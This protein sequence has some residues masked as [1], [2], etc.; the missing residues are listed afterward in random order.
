MDFNSKLDDLVNKATAYIKKPTPDQSADQYVTNH[1]MVRAIQISKDIQTLRE[2]GNARNAL[3]LFRMLV[4]RQILLH[5]LALEDEFDKFVDWSLAC[6]YSDLGEL[7]E[8]GLLSAYDQ[9]RAD[10]TRRDIRERLGD[11]PEKPSYY[12]K[13][14]RAKDMFRNAAGNKTIADAGYLKMYQLSS[15]KV[16]PVHDDS[17]QSDLEGQFLIQNTYWTLGML[18]VTGLIVINHVDISQLILQEVS[19]TI[20]LQPE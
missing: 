10:E 2:V 6:R 15:A 17:F 13:K 14:P 20:G 11:K 4:D 5:Q 1:F 19:G 16:H 18:L 3:A 12:W 7:I 8:T 9:Q